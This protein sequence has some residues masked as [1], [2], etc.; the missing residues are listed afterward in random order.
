MSVIA[1]MEAQLLRNSSKDLVND[2]I[3]CVSGLFRTTL[4]E[5]RFV[6]GIPGV[7]PVLNGGLSSQL[8]M[9]SKDIAV[10]NTIAFPIA[11]RLWPTDGL[12]EKTE[13]ERMET[14]RRLADGNWVLAEVTTMTNGLISAQVLGQLEERAG[15][16]SEGEWVP[17]VGTQIQLGRAGLGSPA[18]PF[19]MRAMRGGGMAA[20]AQRLRNNPATVAVA[21]GKDVSNILGYN[22]EKS[23]GEE[24]LRPESWL[25]MYQDVDG[26][27]HLCSDRRLMEPRLKL[28]ISCFRIMSE[29]RKVVYLRDVQLDLA[30]FMRDLKRPLLDRGGS[31]EARDTK[32]RDFGRVHRLVK[33]PVL[34]S[35]KME[36]FL[37]Q[38]FGLKE[39][40]RRKDRITLEDLVSP[41]TWRSVD[42]HSVSLD[43]RRT[44]EQAVENLEEL[45]WLTTGE[46]TFQQIG[47]KLKRYLQE[48]RAEHTT[49]YVAAKIEL[50]LMDFSDL[51]S[52]LTPISRNRW[53]LEDGA[54][55]LAQVLKAALDGIVEGKERWDAY[56]HGLFWERHAEYLGFRNTTETKERRPLAAKT[57]E[58]GLTKNQKKRLKKEAAAAAASTSVA[59]SASKNLTASKKEL[60]GNPAVSGV[61]EKSSGDKKPG[62][63]IADVRYK[64]GLTATPC[65]Y[66]GKC[67]FSHTESSEW[68]ST[69]F[70]DRAWTERVEEDSSLRT[71]LN[72]A[73][74][75]L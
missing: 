49:A 48:A 12:K 20:I 29:E 59:V 61:V 2:H 10:G 34:E 11:E 57:E 73:G 68:R 53:K 28:W 42:V 51:V 38:G 31:Y 4:A 5:M 13:E 60:S 1:R 18:F 6:D 70:K 44:L 62:L 74:V 21:A 37:K 35:S 25:K 55:G 64:L 41:G 63:C 75:S 33:C 46:P 56:P 15:M 32:G 27:E 69:D 43:S 16:V 14:A 19:L 58:A 26:R 17:A 24:M 66:A 47:E 3:E 54:K 8:E 52:D 45:Y 23:R 9:V 71:A 72:T 36:M 65:K 67:R 50:A 30:T 7:L 22:G 39:K 40:D